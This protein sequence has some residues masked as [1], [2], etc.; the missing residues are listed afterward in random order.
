VVVGKPFLES[1]L[2]CGLNRRSVFGRC[3]KVYSGAG[4]SAL[5]TRAIP[6][7]KQ[8]VCARKDSDQSSIGLFRTLNSYYGRNG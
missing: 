4:S 6:E 5:N 3:D 7:L 2:L 8:G 1:E